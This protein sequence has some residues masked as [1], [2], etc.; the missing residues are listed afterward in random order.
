[1]EYIE[2][3]QEVLEILRAASGSFLSAYQVCQDI[4]KNNDALWS[5]LTDAYPSID[6]PVPMG[7]GTGRH[8]SPAS[9]VAGA[10][11]HFTRSRE[12]PGLR[13]EMFS[14][15]GVVFSGIGA[16]N[17]EKAIGIWAITT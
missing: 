10:L 8:Y 11:A 9:F 6:T 12:I 16:C 13:Q 14:C 17:T 1:M 15:G 2:I 4:E 7:T 3:Q 5:R